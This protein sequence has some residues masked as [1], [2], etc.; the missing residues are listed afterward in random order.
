[1]TGFDEYISSLLSPRGSNENIFQPTNFD[2][3]VGQDDIKQLLKIAIKAAQNEN[4]PLPNLMIS[5]AFGLGKTSLAMLVAKEFGGNYE[6]LDGATV[7]KKLP[8]GLVIIDEIHNL[9]SEVSDSLN[10]HIDKNAIQ[11]IGCTTNPGALTGAFRSRFRVYNLLT[12]SA[13]ELTLIAQNICKRKGVTADKS[14]LYEIALRSRTNARQ[15]TNLL[16]QVFDLMAVKQKTLM[17]HGLVDETFALLDVDEHGYLERDRRYVNAL[18]D[19]PVGLNWLSSVLGIDQTT[20]Q[21]EIEP[22]LLQTGIIDR[23][24]QGRVKIQSI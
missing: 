21:E 23:T 18:P 1:M 5:G 4:R 15:L 8:K 20:I 3:Y 9:T 14:I 19:R 11:I 10:M 7:N 22:Y 13:D 16:S 2:E 12:Y 24:G 6:L 17:V